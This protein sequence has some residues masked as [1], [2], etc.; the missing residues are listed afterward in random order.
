MSEEL[1]SPETPKINLSPYSFSS[2]PVR[3]PTVVI[4]KKGGGLPQ[5]LINKGWAR[6]IQK[7]NQILLGFVIVVILLSVFIFWWMNKP[8]SNSI[9]PDILIDTTLGVPPHLLPSSIESAL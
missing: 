7:A 3:P 2:V 9:P 6:N 8:P 5:W 1:N 4:Q